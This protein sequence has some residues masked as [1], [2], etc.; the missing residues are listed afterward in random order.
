LSKK[1]TTPENSTINSTPAQPT[2]E[3]SRRSDDAV[4]RIMEQ[5]KAEKPRLD[6]SAMALIGRLKRCSALITPRL[7]RV[8][9][10]YELSGWEFDVL[11]T[12]RRAGAPY[13][14]APTLL[15]N[16]LMVSS[17][18][19]THR[20][21]QLEKKALI[22]R[23]ADKKDARSKLV[24]LTHS[25]FQLIDKAVDE[26]VQ[27]ELDMLSALGHEDTAKLNEGLVVLLKLLEPE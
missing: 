15:F 19:M 9:S 21:I 17:G 20:L 24:Q 27:N 23:V 12:L 26:H 8:F 14:L 4:D 18:T 11:A 6:L 1:H 2:I 5:W 16:T 22:K 13:C 25:G 10:K 3:P 7:D